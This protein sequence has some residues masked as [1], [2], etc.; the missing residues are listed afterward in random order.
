MNE[1]LLRMENITK[2]FPGT[3]ALDDVS[4]DCKKGEVH[5][6]V[7]ENGAGKSTLMKILSGAYSQDLGSIYFRGEQINISDPKHR[8]ALGIGIIMQEF[9]LLPYLSVEENIFLGREKKTP[10]GLIDEKY[11]NQESQKLLSSLNVNIDPKTK[12]ERLTTAQMQFVEIA[13]AL[14]LGADLLIMD[15]PSA[16]LTGHELEYLFSVI[17]VL[18][19][20]G[21]SIIYISHR[22]VEIFQIAD[23][24]TIL[25][26]GKLMGTKGIEEVTRDKLVELMVGRTVSETFPKRTGKFGDCMISVEN[27]SNKTLPNPINLEI[28]CGEILGLAGLVGSGRT[29]LAKAIFGSD[30][31]ETGSITI[32][33]RKTRIKN[34]N[35]AVKNGVVLIPEDRK[36]EGLVGIR[37]IQQNISLPNLDHFSLFGFIKSQKEKQEVQNS[38]EQL[39]IRCSGMTQYVQDLSGGNQQKVVLAKWLVRL[40]NVII[41]DEPTRGIDV[42]AK[43]E[44]YQIMRNLA[45]KGLAILMISSELPEILGMADRVL[46]MHERKIV[47]ELDG[48]STTEEEIMRAATGGAVAIFEDQQST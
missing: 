47:A 13:K 27:I 17:E 24:V 1:Y 48:A 16:T 6:L 22:L 5:A 46:V 2:K 10:L 40:P 3:I 33:S 36:L 39:S 38:I 12:I 35:D 18:K 23:R 15:E 9:N 31:T 29:E 14:S 28:R 7:G 25:K 45:N 26:D 44:I 19:K 20:K 4:F 42:G 32:K 8:Q 41:L 43:S 37:T 34:P 11:I 30:S 21:T